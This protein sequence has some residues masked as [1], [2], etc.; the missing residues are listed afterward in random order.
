MLAR[1]TFPLAA[2]AVLLAGCTNTS[3]PTQSAGSSED[4]SGAARVCTVTPADL[5]RGAAATVQMQV[6]NDGGWCAVRV[7]DKDGTAYL[8]PKLTQ[9]Q[10]HGGVK[11]QTAAGLTRIEYT[12]AANYAGS[13][14]FTV[15]LTPKDK[16]ADIPLRVTVTVT[17]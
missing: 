4:R 3:A 1:L 12:P 14:A 8:Y 13:D 9:R 15:A 5:P 16:S 6:G 7:T 11:V 17:K 10:S 2:A